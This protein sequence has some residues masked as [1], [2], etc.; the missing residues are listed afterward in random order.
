MPTYPGDRNRKIGRK[1]ENDNPVRKWYICSSIIALM[2]GV[3]IAL[4]RHS[5]FRH[6]PGETEK[7][8]QKGCFYVVVSQGSSG[9]KMGKW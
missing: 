8:L 1:N 5:G 9:N 2:F 4:G 7:T 3:F 6:V